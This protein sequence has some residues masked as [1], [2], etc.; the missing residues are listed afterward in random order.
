MVSLVWSLALRLWSCLV[1]FLFQPIRQFI[2]NFGKILLLYYHGKGN[3]TIL[4][5][6]YALK[7]A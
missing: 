4:D 1:G 2:H 7:M 6:S 3:I 5:I